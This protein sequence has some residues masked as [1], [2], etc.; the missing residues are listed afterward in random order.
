[1][2]SVIPPSKPDTPQIDDIQAIQYYYGTGLCNV[3]STT[4]C[5]NGSRFRVTAATHGRARAVRR[6][7]TQVAP[8]TFDTALAAAVPVTS[9]T[10]YFWFSN[11]SDVDLVV[12]VIDG[13]ATNGKFWVLYG[14]LSDLEYTITVTDTETKAVK[15]YF[16]PVGQ[17]ASVADKKAF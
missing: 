9:D 3:D 15:T 17:L 10:G 11:S 12:R 6:G 1:M 7:S 8:A 14:S 13:R 5:L 2:R 16:N 4:L